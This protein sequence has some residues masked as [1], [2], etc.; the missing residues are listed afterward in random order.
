MFFI[1]YLVINVDLSDL[2][3]SFRPWYIILTRIVKDVQQEFQ[4]FMTQNLTEE[5]IQTMQNVLGKK[6]RNSLG[7]KIRQSVRYV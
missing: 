7:F 4:V 6:K 2:L 5:E 1:I 3:I